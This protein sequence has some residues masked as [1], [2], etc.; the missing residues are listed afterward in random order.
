MAGDHM[1]SQKGITL[2]FGQRERSLLCRLN[3]MRNDGELCDVTI[4][5]EDQQF[6]CHRMVLAAFSSYFQSLFDVLNR[7]GFVVAVSVR[8]SDG[9]KNLKASAFAQLLDYLYTGSIRVTK[10][11]AANIM[12]AANGRYF[13]F[14]EVKQACTKLLQNTGTTADNG[15]CTIVQ[16]SGTLA[17]NGTIVQNLGTV[18]GN[19]TGTAN[20]IIVQ[21]SGTLAGNGA[22]VQNSET[23]AGNGTIVQN[24][25]T[26]AGNGTGTGNGTIVQNSGAQSENGTI[27]QN[28]GKSMQAGNGTIVQNSGTQAGNGTIVQN[29]GAQAGNSTIVQNSGAQA[30]NGTIVQNSGTEE[31]NRTIVQNSGTQAGNSTIVQNS[32]EQAGNGTIVQNAEAQA[33]K[34]TIVQNSGAQAGN[35]TIVQNSGAQSGNG[36]IVQNS[37]TEE[38]NRTIV[39]NSGTQAGNGTIVQNSGEQAGN[40]TIVQ[41]AEAL[42]GNGT[43]VQNSRAQAGNPTITQKL[44]TMPEKWTIPLNS[45]MLAEKCTIPQNLGIVARN[46]TVLQDLGTMAENGTIVQNSGTLAKNSATLPNSGT[47]VRSSQGRETGA[48]ASRSNDVMQ[49]TVGINSND[50]VHGKESLHGG[51]TCKTT[52]KQN[53]TYKAAASSQSAPLQNA[54]IDKEKEKIPTCEE[55]CKPLSKTFESNS[56]QDT[57]SDDNNVSSSCTKVK[58]KEEV[59]EFQYLSQLTWTHDAKK[60][61]ADADPFDDNPKEEKAREEDL[62]QFL[63]NELEMELG[64][65]PTIGDLD[66]EPIV[67]H[68]LGWFEEDLDCS[69]GERSEV[70]STIDSDTD[71]G[72]SEGGRRKRKW[73]EETFQGKKRSKRD[74]DSEASAAHTSDGSALDS[75][76]PANYYPLFISKQPSTESRIPGAPPDPVRKDLERSKMPSNPIMFFGDFGTT[77]DTNLQGTVHVNKPTNM[78]MAV[79]SKR[80]AFPHSQNAQLKT[81]HNPSMGVKPR[82]VFMSFGDRVVARDLEVT[83]T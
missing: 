24:L 21:N 79:M 66:E 60:K 18:A 15:T 45:Q 83:Q 17:G 13:N 26:V 27:V 56:M 71:C 77:Q 5:V 46:G 62:N 38:G 50:D 41:N 81:V 74:I 78:K 3:Q 22:I 61:A 23:P 48:L 37:G 36:T 35:G 40:G 32:G 12:H 29:S 14:E 9:D 33:G 7:K 47:M 8:L 68:S 64:G 34:G 28:L 76:S 2:T 1:Y 75:H 72:D 20:G 57:S 6:R 55:V 11:S 69:E 49:K 58:V 43:I 65:I 4:I 19:C 31:G 25:G 51:A 44:V 39:Q 53:E 30:R 16:N 54:G 10:Q 63:L 82:S 73:S 42:A 80:G 70:R 52:D 67:C 59:Q